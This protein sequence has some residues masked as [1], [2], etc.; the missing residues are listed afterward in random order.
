MLLTALAQVCWFVFLEWLN[1]IILTL[2]SA[3]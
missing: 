3:E 1:A 2:E